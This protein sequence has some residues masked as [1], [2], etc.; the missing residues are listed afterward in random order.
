MEKIVSVTRSPS[1]QITCIETSEGRCIS[2]MK[3]LEEAKAGILSG[4]EN[5]LFQDEPFHM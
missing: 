4:V 3:A 5:H 1:G 2:Y